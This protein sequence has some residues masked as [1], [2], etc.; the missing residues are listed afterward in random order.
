MYHI[1]TWSFLDIKH[2][3]KVFGDERD[4]L[5]AH[6]NM[7]QAGWGCGKA[8][9]SPNAPPLELQP[10]NQFCRF[11]AVGYNRIPSGKNQ[12]TIVILIINK[13]EE[14]VK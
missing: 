2:L 4:S 13:K 14:D 9:Y 8:F 5:I 1:S 12:D 7:I 11:R 6:W 10:D 3:F